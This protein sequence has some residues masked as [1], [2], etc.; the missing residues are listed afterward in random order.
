MV[1]A[2]AAGIMGESLI[3]SAAL[4]AMSSAEVEWRGHRFY[5]G[6]RGALEPVL[7]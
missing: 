2:I 1:R 6:E 5:V 4:L 7:D 3:L